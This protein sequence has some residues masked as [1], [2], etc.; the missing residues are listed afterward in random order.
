MKTTCCL[1]LTMFFA[2][3]GSGG[4][5]GESDAVDS[6]EIDAVKADLPDVIDDVSKAD[7]DAADAS[8]DQ[9]VHDVKPETLAKFP[10]S[11]D[12]SCEQDTDCK[13]V[14]G[15]G[16]CVEGTCRIKPLAG[17]CL[18]AAGDSAA[19]CY[20][21]GQHSEAHYCLFCNTRVAQDRLVPLAMEEDF[22]EAPLNFTP[23]VQDLTGGGVTWTV[24]QNR[25]L[26][27]QSSLYFGIP[28]EWTY[29]NGAHVGAEARFVGM[30]I[31]NAAGAMLSFFMFMDTE[32]TKG[33][34][35]LVVEVRS[36]DEA[37]EVFNSDSV[38]GTSQG[39]F[40]P[41]EVPLDAFR[42]DT[43]DVAF[44]FDSVDG[45]I[46]SYEGVYLDGIRISSGCCSASSDCDDG[47]P[48]TD[49]TCPDVG[50]AC[51]NQDRPECCVTDS[52]CADEDSCT[53]DWCPVS[54]KGC[55]FDPISGCCHVDEDCDDGDECTLDSCPEDGGQ[56]L[57]LPGCCDSVEDCG[58]PATCLVADCVDGKCEYQDLCCHSDDDCDDMDPCTTDKC[59]QG[60]CSHKV[61]NIP[62]CCWPDVLSTG[63]DAGP[64]GFTTDPAVGGVGW[65]IVTNGKS[66]SPPGALYYGNPANKDYDNGQINKGTAVSSLID[67]PV[68]FGAALTFQVFMDTESSPNYDRLTVSWR[69]T[70]D[71]WVLWSKDSNLAQSTFVK[72]EVNMSA[73]AGR[74]G[75]LVFFFDTVD[76]TVNYGEGVYVDDLAVTSTCSPVTCAV[77]DDC[78]DALSFTKDTC[79][80][81]MCA[82]ELQAP[83]SGDE[84]STDWDCDDFDFCT[85]DYCVNGKCVFDIDPWCWY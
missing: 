29:G 21:Q 13:T 5:A 30:E 20:M 74:G 10:L 68:G 55:E 40:I 83:G 53:W 7:I 67:I 69:E 36:G 2:A 62:G 34:D 75:R 25:A 61:S 33:Y 58:S 44:I 41:I 79:S 51:L 50:E 81:G 18:D 73:F 11:V 45:G 3:C 59:E 76:S 82:W 72:I 52:D 48:C 9:S 23:V 19:L 64:S 70:D 71:E 37:V 27:G 1:L 38:G 8:P 56:C 12:L 57:H 22:E 17:Y 63:F 15:N 16:T 80:A 35:Y 54:G 77:D 47:N 60:D 24:S 6:F 26:W 65:S 84:C 66:V 46:N 43:V 4:G 32:E 39:V 31:P 49:D 42:G 14:C 28:G 78:D 85:Y